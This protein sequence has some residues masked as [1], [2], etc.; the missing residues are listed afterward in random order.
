MATLTGRMLTP[1]DVHHL[2]GLLSVPAG[3]ENVEVVP[4][5]G[6]VGVT[7]TTRDRDGHVTAFHGIEAPGA[8]QAPRRG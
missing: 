8:R 7:I 3:P 4:G 6:D 2:V 5:D 1:V